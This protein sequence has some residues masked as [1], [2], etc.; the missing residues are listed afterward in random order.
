MLSNGFIAQKISETFWEM[1]FISCIFNISTTPNICSARPAQQ[2]KKLLPYFLV[3][4][5]FFF[6]VLLF[7]YNWNQGQSYIVGLVGVNC[8]KKQLSDCRQQSLSP[9]YIIN[10]SRYTWLSGLCPFLSF[11]FSFHFPCSLKKKKRKQ[12]KPNITFDNPI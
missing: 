10:Q 9:C 2:I 12:K 11:S 1:V 7:S 4:H 5:L 6:P 8:T 3:L